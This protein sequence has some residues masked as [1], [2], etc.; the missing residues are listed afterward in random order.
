MAQISTTPSILAFLSRLVVL[1]D[2]VIPAWIRLSGTATMAKRPVL[3]VY[4][5]LE[6]VL[7]NEQASSPISLELAM[8][9]TLLWLSTVQ[10]PLN[11]KPR[12][13][14]QNSRHRQLA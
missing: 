11:D 12:G 4:Y 14:Q 9:E 6:G 1:L 5:H 8:L 3:K 7:P 10:A 13:I 2:I